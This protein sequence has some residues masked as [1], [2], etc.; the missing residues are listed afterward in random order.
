MGNYATFACQ[1][2]HEAM[3]MVQEALDAVEATGER[4]Y[5]AE[6]YRLRG[7]LAQSGTSLDDG[8]PENDLRTARRIA[9]EQGAK[10]LELRAT[11]SLARLC[12]EQGRR[13]EARDLLAP[14]YG[15]FNEGLVTADL[16]EARTLL[17]GLN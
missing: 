1:D 4:W 13:V 9:A 2:T 3:A 12:G 15:W 10:L 7:I 8:L 11:V 14:V 5:E 17:V 16:K 6:L